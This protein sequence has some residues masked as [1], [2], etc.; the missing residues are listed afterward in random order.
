MP[1]SM[2]EGKQFTRE[3]LLDKQVKRVLDVGPGSGNYY[4]LLN[5]RGEYDGW[6]PPNNYLDIEWVAVEIYE[7]YIRL[8]NLDI[9]YDVILI[10]DAYDIDWKM[11]GKFDVVFL[12]DVLEHMTQ[13]R[14]KEVIRKAVNHADWVIISLPIVDYPQGPSYGN[15][16][17]THVEQYNPERM[18]DMLGDYTIDASLEGEVVGVYIIHGS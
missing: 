10:S 1:G 16:H 13:D 14:G 9:K 17:E 12:G 5:C 4:D 18:K 11:L 7:P 6:G 3:F 2:P 8:F 15:V